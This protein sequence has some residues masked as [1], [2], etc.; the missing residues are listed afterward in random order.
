MR[1]K[2][3]MFTFLEEYVRWQERSTKHVN[4]TKS[5]C[6]DWYFWGGIIDMNVCSLCT[7]GDM[8]PI[9]LDPFSA[10]IS[11]CISFSFY[12]PLNFIDFLN[13]LSFVT[14]PPL[15]HRSASDDDAKP[16]Y[17]AQYDTISH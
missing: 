14:L 7:P 10:L 6:H 15:R 12:H 1:E 5:R 13:P 16:V 2:Y 3:G 9:E 17:K 8:R 4:Y 11:S